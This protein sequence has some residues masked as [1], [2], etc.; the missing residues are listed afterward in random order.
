MSDLE[1]VHCSYLFV[2]VSLAEYEA[3]YYLILP[4]EF[5]YFFIRQYFQLR[6]LDFKN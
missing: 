1:V 4:E 2:S 5:Y 6:F 3:P